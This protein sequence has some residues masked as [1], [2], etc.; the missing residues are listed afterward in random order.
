MAY[1][2]IKSVYA[3]EI[4]SFQNNALSQSTLGVKIEENIG[5][6]FVAI[7]RVETGFDPMYGELADA[8]KS[9]IAANA[10]T[11][12]GNPA[13][14]LSP[15]IDGSRC[16]QAFNGQVY[17][18][19]SS[20]TFGTLTY[21]RQNS[22][23]N[24][25]VATYDPNHGSYAFSLIGYSGG[26][27]AGVGSTETAR[28]DNSV[29]YVYQYG[30]V[31]VGGMYAV[32][33]SGS[34]IQD[35]AYGANAGLTF[36]GLS[37][38]GYYTNEKGAVNAS[39]GNA[40]QSATV[41]ANSLN[42]TITNNEAYSVA[43]KYTF[44][45]GGGFKDGGCGFKDVCDNSKLTF[46]GGYNHTDQ[47]NPDHAQSAYNGGTTIGDYVFYTLSAAANTNKVIQTAWVGATYETGPWSFTGAYY[48]Q[49]TKDNVANNVGDLNWVSGVVDYKFN[50]NFDIY[51]GVTYAEYSGSAYT[52]VAYPLDNTSV[53]TGLRL[54][55]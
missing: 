23:L 55:F 46:F 38:D 34:S 1:A 37:V 40:F 24:D 17:A 7:G 30:P 51:A 53:V 9:L 12:G 39:S 43:A 20:A 6:G 45:F 22:F 52:G 5:A 18:G 21:G 48:T 13:K 27:L 47:T 35:D 4:S 42:A 3:R 36:K 25:A 41:S 14:T 8:C 28:W 2:P 15:G 50:K 10:A 31:H 32:G 54:K 16:G 19:T 26:A 29:K 33:G 44:E 11:L 49:D